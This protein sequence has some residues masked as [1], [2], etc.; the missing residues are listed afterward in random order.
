M[1]ASLTSPHVDSQS[2]PSDA[3]DARDGTER[4]RG[5]I[6]LRL[7]LAALVVA[8]LVAGATW[9]TGWRRGAATTAKADKFV[10]QPR[11]FSVVLKEKGELKAA[12]ST[13]V[14]CEVEGRSTIISLV[15]EGTA[16]KKGDLLVEL[17]SDQIEDRIRQEEL[18]ESNAV[19]AYQASKTE[20][21]I[22]RDKNASDI[23]KANLEIKL[24]SLALEKYQKGDW[25]QKLKDAQIAIDQAKMTYA[26]SKEDFEAEAQLY[27][28]KWSTKTAYEDAKFKKQKAEWDVEKAEKAMEVLKVYTHVADLAQ[29][30]SDYEEAKKEAER[31]KKNAEA[32]EIK[33]LRAMEG[34][35]KELDLLRDQLAKLRRQKEKSKIYAPTD[36]IV[37]YYG[38]GGRHFISMDGSGQIKE[39]ATVYE[40][41]VLMSLPDTSEMK[42]LVR[43]HEA[44]TDRLALGQ[45]VRIRIE[46]LQDREF[47]GRVTKIAA[48]ADSQNRWLN[49]DLRE[50]ETEITLDLVDVPLKPGVTAHTEILV[51]DVDSKAAVPVQAVYSKGGHRFVF[52]T[53]GRSLKPVEVTLGAI[54]TE[55]ADITKGISP[56]DEVLLAFADEHKRLI[57]DFPGED[58]ARADGNR[59]SRRRPRSG[60]HGGPPRHG[61]TRGRPT[62]SAETGSS[63]AGRASGDVKLP[64][65]VLTALKGGKVPPSVAGALKAGRLPDG[66]VTSGPKGSSSDSAPDTASAASKTKASPSGNQ[67]AAAPAADSSKSSSV[68]RDS[69]SSNDSH[70]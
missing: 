20:L 10:V 60:R 41:Q 8:L 47:S 1:T 22:Q 26:R 28:R 4:H 30:Q 54:G 9:A 14:S 16:V 64:A 36:G 17:A 31:T 66:T 45:S 27:Q 12:K 2:L 23:R 57:P 15:P 25:S 62:A 70:R 39:G 40:R 21:E 37:I 32:E 5:R 6:G 51:E 35:K 43:V 29:R 48:V 49:P 46:G 65:A 67:D 34:K 13:D 68:D 11:H 52:V 50:Y 3:Y 55:W 61:T 56:G 59:R 24:K 19:T 44:K 7:L 53:S 63:Y 58:R 18:K 33:K 69:A 42:V 38:G